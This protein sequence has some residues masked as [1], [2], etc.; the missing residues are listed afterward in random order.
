MNEPI[1]VLTGVSKAFGPR[2]VLDGASLLVG[3]GET[4]AV[5]GPSG[6]GKSTTLNIAG[7][8]DRP[9]RGTVVVDGT[10]ATPLTENERAE[11]R[12]S[13]IGMVFQH[14]HLLPHMSVL[15]NVMLGARYTALGLRALR[16]AA[17]E[18]LERV[19]LASA[20]AQ[21]AQTLSRGEAQRVALGRAL[22]RSPRLL[23]CDETT[24]SL[25]DANRDHVL[26]ILVDVASQGTAVLLVSHDDAVAS[27]AQRVL[28]LGNGRFTPTVSFSAAT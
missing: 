21:R 2:V 23:L 6:V 19:G 17:L 7:L 22:T 11:L 1:L 28:S 18:A 12:R 15:E 13:S 20:A 27:I 3:P 10:D 24:A 9:D 8:L 14:D 5:V 16:A 4:V 25:D 26:D